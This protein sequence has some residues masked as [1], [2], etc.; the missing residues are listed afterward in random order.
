MKGRKTD[1][2]ESRTEER[3]RFAETLG[4]RW[5]E[6]QRQ[7]SQEKKKIYTYSFGKLLISFFLSEQ[8]GYR[9]GDFPCEIHN[10]G[11]FPNI[12]VWISMYAKV[13]F[14][15]TYRTGCQVSPVVELIHHHAYSCHKFTGR[16]RDML[17][18]KMYTFAGGNKMNYSHRT[19]VIYIIHKPSVFV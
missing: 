1:R 10:I 19:E 2:R 14:F 12:T 11:F 16:C 8:E 7:K 18:F 9:S 4:E 5:R 3:F 13:C 15:S 17:L 6:G